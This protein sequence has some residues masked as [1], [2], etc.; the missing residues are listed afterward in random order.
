MT[1]S[2]D[3]WSLTPPSDV[4]P[5][6]ARPKET[7]AETRHRL[8]QVRQETM[9]QRHGPGPEGQTCAGCWHWVSVEG[10]TR[11]YRKC[12]VYG[13]SQAE[14]TDWRGRWPACGAFVENTP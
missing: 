6:P 2:L 3:D 4:V 1:L 5:E 8:E 10:N 9:R 12:E 13:I 7:R 11:Y 14:S